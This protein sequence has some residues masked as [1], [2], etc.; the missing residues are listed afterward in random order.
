M[1]QQGQSKKQSSKQGRNKI[2]CDRYRSR[3]KRRKSA[4]RRIKLHLKRCANDSGALDALERITKSVHHVRGEYGK[5]K[6][7]RNG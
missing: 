4:L 7:L 1:A 5:A 3:D 2:K 6:Q